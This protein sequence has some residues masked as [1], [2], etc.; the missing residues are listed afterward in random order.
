MGSFND[1]IISR[2]EDRKKAETKTR[3]SFNDFVVERN[4]GESVT[5][6]NANTI[7]PVTTSN[8]T[9][10]PVSLKASEGEFNRSSAMQQKYGTYSNYING[11]VVK[12]DQP[13]QEVKAPEYPKNQ[14]ETEKKKTLLQ[15]LDEGLKPKENTSSTST[16][17]ESK[18]QSG[19]K[20]FGAM[21]G[22]AIEAQSNAEYERLTDDK[23][24]LEEAAAIGAAQIPVSIGT[25][26]AKADERATRK[27]TTMSVPEAQKK[28]G[29][30]TG[31]QKS[32]VNEFSDWWSDLSN[33]AQ[34]QNGVAYGAGKIVADVAIMNGISSVVTPA[35]GKA[36]SAITGT[37]IKGAEW[38]GTAK[39]TLSPIATTI[40]N[41]ASK[42]V[43][44]AMTFGIK[45]A[46]E[47]AG[48]ASTNKITG[49]E[50]F[51]G[52]VKS[53]A[54][55]AIFSVVDSV[56]SAG[57]TNILKGLNQR[58]F[59]TANTGLS[60][61]GSSSRAVTVKG[62]DW[63]SPFAW[64]TKEIIAG[65]GAASASVGFDYATA[66]PSK[67]YYEQMRSVYPGIS[68]EQIES[69]YKNQMKEGLGKQFLTMF[70]FSVISAYGSTMNELAKT[71]AAGEVINQT[72]QHCFGEKLLKDIE[73]YAFLS[74][75]EKL[76]VQNEIVLATNRA[77]Y[78]LD[79][80][81]L[82][83]TTNG[84]AVGWNQYYKDAYID[85]PLEAIKNIYSAPN[86]ASAND[87]SRSSS[88]TTEE[89]E[90]GLQ[91]VDTIKRAESTSNPQDVSVKTEV[92]A[93]A[94]NVATVPNSLEPV[95][96]AGI[97]PSVSEATQNN[98]VTAQPQT[99]APSIVLPTATE[100]ARIVDPERAVANVSIPV[101]NESLVGYNGIDN[102]T[103]MKGDTVNG[104]R[105]I[106][107]PQG[108]QRTYGQSPVERTGTVEKTTGR[109]ESKG[110][111]S[112]EN[113]AKT[114][115]AFRSS[116]TENGGVAKIKSVADA[117]DKSISDLYFGAEV[118]S[119][120]Y[121]G[122]K[123]SSKTKFREVIGGD[124]ETIREARRLAKEAGAELILIAGDDLSFSNGAEARAAIRVVGGKVQIVSRVDDPEANCVQLTQ[125]E[126]G[127]KK[128]REGIL[129]VDKAV[130]L[131]RKT[132][133]GGKELA[134]TVINEYLK[135]KF[136]EDIVSASDEEIQRAIIELVCDTLGDIDEVADIKAY[137]PLSDGFQDLKKAVLDSMNEGS[138]EVSESSASV[139]ENKK[140]DIE[141]SNSPP[142][143]VDGVAVAPDVAKIMASPEYHAPMDYMDT[144][145]GTRDSWKKQY[146]KQFNSID[147]QRVATVVDEFTDKMISNPLIMGYVPVG[148]YKYS[149]TG[150]IRKNIE[151]RITFDMDTSCPRTFQFLNYRNKIQEAAGRYL[152][153]NESVNLLEL[154]RAYGQQ[155]PCA[156]CYVENKRVLLSA[157]Y[158]NY[159]K[160][161]Q[162]VMNAETDEEAIKLMYSYNEKTGEVSDAARKVFDTWRADRS[163]NPSVEETWG[164]TQHSRNAIL[165]FLDA[166]KQSGNI[167]GKTSASTIKTK[168]VSKFNL[169]DKEAIR[170]AASYIADWIYDVNA[171]IPHNYGVEPIGETIVDQR[172]LKLNRQ[173]LAYAK[174]ASSAKTVE[175]YQ[176]YDGQ[177][178]N[179]DKNTK[180]YVIGMGGVRKHSSNDFRI[181]YVQDYFM[182]FADLASGGWTGHTYT[183]N[184]DYV[185]IFGRTEDRINMSIAMYGDTPETVR[186]NLDEGMAW[187]D[188]RNLRN[189]YKT[190]GVM[191]MVTN[192]A[193]LSYAL[194]SKWIDMIIPFHASGL[195]KAVWYNLRMWLDYTSKQLERFYNSDDKKAALK[196]KGVE[197]PKGA[198]ADQISKLFDDT[199]DIKK[200]RDAAGN[201]VRPHF[202]P[203][204]TSING[205]KVPGH[206]NDPKRYMEL[207]EQY[208]VHPRFY[209][210]EVTDANGKTID[211]TEHPNYIKL[212][213]E[214][215]RI[216]TEQ[217]PIKFNFDEVDP[218][219]GETPMDYAMRRMEEEAKNGGYKNTGDDKYGIVEEFKNEYLGKDRPLGYLTERA[220]QYKAIRDKEQIKAGKE[221][222]KKLEEL[223]NDP[224]DVYLSTRS[225]SSYI[226]DDS[227]YLSLAQDP[228][229]NRYSLSKMVE[230]SALENGAAT[231]EKGNAIVLYHG[232]P[233][234]GFTSFDINA[235]KSSNGMIYTTTKREVAANYGRKGDYAFSRDI[236]KPFMQGD[237]VK[238]TIHNAEKVLG[239]KLHSITKE[240]RKNIINDAI[241]GARKLSEKIDEFYDDITSFPGF[242]EGEEYYNTPAAFFDG[243]MD[244]FYTALGEYEYN[245]DG[246]LSKSD[247]DYFASA[248]NSFDRNYPKFKEYLTEIYDKVNG[249][250]LQKVRDFLIGF[251]IIDTAAP[252]LG[253]M[254]YAIDGDETVLTDGKKV[255]NKSTIDDLISVNKNS[256]AYQLYGFPGD[257]VL[258]VDAD[259]KDWLTLKVLD[260]D[261]K[262][263]STDY[264][265][266]WAIKN[267]YTSMIVKN[268]YDG[269]NMADDYIFFSPNQVK[270]ADS[271]SYDDLGNVIPL[272]ERFNSND[273][274]IR[275]SS[276][277]SGNSIS[278]LKKENDRLK[279]KLE[280][281][282]RQV[283]LTD[284][285][286]PQFTSA[287][288]TRIANTLIKDTGA[289]LKS[290]E[291]KTE[292]DDFFRYMA[293]DDATNEG[294]RD[295]AGTVASKLIQ[296]AK[297]K[298]SP[299]ID[300]YNQLKSYLKDTKLSIKNNHS[301]VNYSEFKKANREIHLADDGLPV[302]VAY[303]ELREVLGEGFFPTD[304]VNPAD[305]LERIADV[306][307]SLKPIYEN[308]Y[309]IYMAEATEWATNMVIDSYWDAK[310]MPD[311]YADK[312]NAK[313]EQNKYKYEQ[314]LET[315]KANAE[316]REVKMQADYEAKLQKQKDAS[317]QK[318]E[319]Q[320]MKDAF[321]YNEK[322]RKSEYRYSYALEKEK[323]KRYE[324]VEAIKQHYKDIS[325]QKKTAQRERNDRQRLLN[326]VKRLS[327]Q[328]MDAQNRAQI[329]EIIKDIDTASI[330][331][332]GNTVKKLADLADWVEAKT[333]KGID[334]SLYDPD[335]IVS[336]SLKAKLARLKKTQIADMTILQVR[337]LTEVLLE[338]E[339]NLRN[340]KNLIDSK[341]KIDT[342]NAGIHVMQDIENAE[343]GHIMRE[344]RPSTAI[345]RMVGFNPESP[346]VTVMNE[347]IQGERDYDV[348]VRSANKIV[349]EF[350]GDHKF[351]QSI[352][353]K[354]AKLVEITGI[355]KQTGK[356]RTIKV[357]PAMRISLYLHLQNDDNLRHLTE[358][359]GVFPN[360]E[361]YLKGDNTMYND[362][363]TLKLTRTAIQGIVSK[364]TEKEI[365]FAN[366]MEL[367]FNRFAPDRMNPVSE[368]LDGW[369]KFTVLNYFPIDTDKNF[370]KTDYEALVTGNEASLAR[371]GFGEERVHSAK[372]IMI[373]DANSVFDQSVRMNG[374]Y[375]T[376]AI[377][378]RNF[379]SL[380]NVQL[381]E[382]RVDEDENGVKMGENIYLEKDVDSVRKALLRKY[383]DG[384]AARYLEKFG[385]DYSGKKG[386]DKTGL[387]KYLE[388]MRSNYS[389]GVLTLGAGTAIKQAASY[390]TAGAIVSTKALTLAMTPAKT[391]DLSFI[392][393]RTAVYT[394]RTEGLSSL[395]QAELTQQGKHIPKALNW[396]QA[397]D[398]GTTK[399]LKRAAYFDVR[400]RKP[401]LDVN[402]E[403]FKEEVVKT[404]IKIIE[405][406][407][408]N[409]SVALRPDILRDQ[410]SLT[411]NLI[412]FATQPLQNFNI[413]YEAIGECN[414]AK[415]KYTNDKSESNKK[416]YNASKK[417]VAK[418][419]SSQI[420]A[421]LVY[422][423][424][425]WAWD[426]YRGKNSKYR[427]D[428]GDITFGSWAKGIGLTFLSTAG[429]M[430]PFMKMAIEAA[431]A[432][433]D[434]I[435]KG[436]G[437]KAI[438]NQTFYGIEAATVGALSDA[439][440]DLI[441]AAGADSAFLLNDGDGRKALKKTVAAAS[442]IL[443]ILGT[444][445]GN[446]LQLIEATVKNIGKWVFK[447]EIDWPL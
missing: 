420:V 273:N 191:A 85:Q 141:R 315:Q 203:G 147:S 398:V 323:Q 210:V 433:T 152:T 248:E 302:D 137:K 12:E 164:I 32:N 298:I 371:P 295:K 343:G 174:S 267:G 376:M 304:I 126:L 240:E 237:S 103:M 219:L 330:G 307:S 102:P 388:K 370:L 46:A 149:K 277:P 109:I 163:Y 411:R 289:S 35:V 112:G 233:A 401:D 146:L 183:K 290:A 364:M 373:R 77:R 325:A 225:K 154:M 337:E 297:E 158:N 56:L 261:D 288:V 53:A 63:T 157:S 25:A 6:A 118:D 1:Y 396:I 445:A 144:S 110:S 123:G 352:Y 200:I 342:H 257:K 403:A 294:M 361:K 254:Q 81:N 97:V 247:R 131:F 28:Y 437:K 145:T 212:I 14:T 228:E 296:S 173:A 275:Y 346:L 226:P 250:K 410:D 438:F 208:G 113:E 199:F 139:P 201:V 188:A 347:M 178:L 390:P 402:G 292:L 265:A 418:A 426:E 117:K 96:A 74:P 441:S 57:G 27:D 423:L 349:S 368:K 443:V 345:K 122:D 278:Q 92:A 355:D 303:E 37:T 244:V 62:I 386:N 61:A 100:P 159:F 280:E 409:Y 44:G 165:N 111:I 395:E 447:K 339:A 106:S 216:D 98:T 189:A 416:A 204:D 446:V 394:K 190:A 279:N 129:I 321:Y 128:I 234:F 384:S 348:Y 156:Y 282:K 166:E 414:A 400:E 50:Y 356:P 311:T 308:P 68:D 169:T 230:N 135:I 256:G 168:V 10:E 238:A 51:G 205:Q 193:Q 185:K 381:T 428:D 206:H 155:I 387:S 124:T 30:Y 235:S 241:S 82:E 393:R 351:M 231:D 214:T 276:A 399:L 442:S 385:A 439:V 358:G 65:M 24:D 107:V 143:V 369:S 45:Y 60:A 220:K 140:P 75:N 33:E 84:Y 430:L 269:G 328:K 287:S 263:H 286:N 336:E 397:V 236:G 48:N 301:D 71:N 167:T 391:I 404:Y 239:F 83:M 245:E 79:S 211:V 246:T 29:A 360:M 192:N 186:E 162:N 38:V 134:N 293:S 305:Q 5:R 284:R 331:I 70:F 95:T 359:G 54:S 36:A 312:A 66:K 223:D 89:T 142:K 197:I 20:R 43:S 130:D 55:G 52:I 176:P 406:T 59:V 350:T 47:E 340:A 120:K 133:R 221:L 15:K 170:E 22:A 41:T 2:E 316:D 415:R 171:E 88:Y 268:V 421:G 17:T 3:K 407:Q 344:L 207:C 374:R 148:S 72:M 357:T 39:S 114:S 299:D 427:N 34:Q 341:I 258:T 333:V 40:V 160:F 69:A 184:V 49:K 138:E 300:S 187:K 18:N 7:T 310:E 383:S 175:N 332:T 80:V 334:D 13:Y 8:K 379:N 153:Y 194:N 196:A 259:G 413:L 227:M 324:K 281:A 354:H 422:S 182:L 26:F 73:N 222:R 11:K 93:A 172:A 285:S 86:Y 217:K 291:I 270:S 9:S 91:L 252:I 136:G 313:L 198:N 132:F 440:Q 249:T 78:I 209:G 119:T 435:L 309:S 104:G 215:A 101:A 372:P 320:K 151:Y 224:G 229:K 108:S 262:Y 327:N 99:E 21:I 31:E 213:K 412:M 251:D 380:L 319:Q 127:H 405:D 105:D 375:A 363:V 436:A 335:F 253:S 425:Q 274:D 271:V 16:E 76:R 317:A 179:V 429:G 125:H 377:P 322:Q 150:P 232:S 283:T 444:P 64:F 180:A 260:I 243:V 366:A 87:Y 255:W 115:G 94:Q 326:V 338:L 266:K 367:Y 195:D 19:L 67:S 434:A 382:L 4:T 362:P 424:M 23:I 306:L 42:A 431:E 177:I 408:P 116:F 353:G 417:N 389:G 202:F 392:D 272:S 329:D 378:L 432:M 121:F 58:S 218:Y 314:K 419:V 90:Y 242:N 161:R 318:L 264:V 181:D 365:R